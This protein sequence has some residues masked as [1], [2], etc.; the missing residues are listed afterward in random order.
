MAKTRFSEY[1]QRLRE[2]AET[3]LASKRIDVA[4]AI[5]KAA[6]KEPLGL[7]DLAALLKASDPGDVSRILIIASETTREEHGDAIGLIAPL[8]IDN[9]CN[10]ACLYCGMSRMNGSL[11][12]ERIASAEQFSNEAQFLQMLGYRTVELVAGG[13]PLDM[14]QINQYINL[15]EMYRFRNVAFFFDTLPSH[16]YRTLC[17]ANPHLTMVHWQETYIREAYERFHPANTPK[18]DYE[19]RLNAIETAIDNGLEKYAIGVLF[20]LADPRLDLLLCIAHGRYLEER[21]GQAPRALGLVRLQP[22]EGA[23]IVVMPC[24]VDEKLHLFLAAVFR[25]AFPR[26]EMIATSREKPAQIEALLRHVATFTNATCTTVPGG[27]SRDVRVGLQTDGQFFH[28]SPTYPAVERR[29]KGLGL[30][31]D[32]CRP[33]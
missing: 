18:G 11:K 15:L 9:H 5:A 12:R 27:Y 2:Q 19:R 16:D 29:V 22:T 17:H 7:D 1:A 13:V 28:D 8:Y 23:K 30:V 3:L 6:A 31:L 21:T 25:L 14:Q 4:S 32:P 10:N 20:G 33:L 26:A 24:P